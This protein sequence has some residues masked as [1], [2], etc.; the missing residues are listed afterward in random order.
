MESSHANHRRVVA[1]TA[2]ALILAG[3][4]GAPAT[5]A[6]QQTRVAVGPFDGAEAERFRARVRRA[7]GTLAVREVRWEQA[8]ADAGGEPRRDR[9]FA[10]LAAAV[11]ARAVVTGEVEAGRTWRLRLTVRDGR[12]GSVVG[13]V[14]LDERSRRRLERLV[15]RSADEALEPLV[16]DARFP[17]AM[18]PTPGG[19]DR[20]VVVRAFEGP[21]ADRFVEVTRELVADT[22]GLA[23]VDDGA[24][25][26]QDVDA[27][28]S[29][30]AERVSRRRWTLTVRAVNG[31][32]ARTLETAELEARSLQGLGQAYLAETWPTLAR[33]LRGSESLTRRSP[34]PPEPEAPAEDEAPRAARD[35]L[36]PP[37]LEIAVG[38]QSVTRTFRYQDDPFGALRPYDLPAWPFI[39]GEL[40]LY[41]GAF[42]GDGGWSH[43]GLHVR[44]D[45]AP[46]LGSTNTD[47]VRFDTTAW[48]LDVG[49]RGRIPVDA[50]E[51]GLLVG[52]GTRIF[53]VEDDDAGG[54]DADVPGWE[55]G[56]LR[57]EGDARISL[58]DALFL[59]VRAAY[60]LLLATGDLGSSAWFPR[61]EGAGAEGEIGLAYHLAG[62]LEARLGFVYRRF[63]FSMNPVPGDPRVAGGG[64][65][66]Y[67]LGTLG[68]AWRWKPPK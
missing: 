53:R 27:Y 61:N 12:D 42:A 7:L 57:F 46:G 60:L 10:G 32:D 64:L 24:L 34:P 14:E 33:A 62:G 5:A 13:D 8:V 44:G 50:S 25:P 21:G 66:Q 39:A 47:G 23:L 17:A 59:R 15:L 58:V 22:A 65:D 19:E 4:L 1:G 54:N 11:E 26:P 16:A 31:A 67:F 18:L 52:W 36:A 28:V 9:D 43:L 6:A 29:G 45:W 35:P 41:P 49:A 40:A 2:L 51:L 63:W 3:V 37:A 48:G 30:V 68:L 38:G 55:Y 56:Y 20:L